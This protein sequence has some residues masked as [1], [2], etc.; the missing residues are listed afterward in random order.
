MFYMIP[1]RVKC[2]PRS[3]RSAAAMK[4]IKVFVA[5]HTHGDPEKIWIDDSL[6][7]AIWA[8]GGSSPPRR[9]SVKVIKFEDGV[10]EVSVP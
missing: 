5:R 9:I 6:N 2:V 3:D 7:K 4:K 8:K 1:L 10:V